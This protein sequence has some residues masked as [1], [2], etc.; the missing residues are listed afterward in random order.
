GNS[1]APH[2]DVAPRVTTNR[3]SLPPPQQR[4]PPHPMIEQAAR[5][6]AA[7]ATAVALEGCG[8]ASRHCHCLARLGQRGV[9]PGNGDPAE[10][11]VR[12]V[13]DSNVF[14]PKRTAVVNQYRTASALA[15]DRQVRCESQS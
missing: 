7:A 3:L 9:G 12:R 4:P 8:G 15:A 11:G 13:T 2:A 5:K 6:R 14:R 10:T 1:A